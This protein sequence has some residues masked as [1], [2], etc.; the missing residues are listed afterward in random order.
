MPVA[1]DRPY[2]TTS[3]LVSSARMHAPVFRKTAP[4]VEPVVEKAQHDP[5]WPWS[6]TPVTA[7]LVV[8][9]VCEW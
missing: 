8:L 1:D 2:I 4:S 3:P 7:P 5:H 6:L 9:R